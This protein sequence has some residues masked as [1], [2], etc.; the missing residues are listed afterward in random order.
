MKGISYTTAKKFC[1]FLGI[2]SKTLYSDLAKHKIEQ[3]NLIF[4]IYSKKNQPQLIGTLT[5]LD[6]ILGTKSRAALI[7]LKNNLQNNPKKGN[8]L[9]AL[10]VKSD[11]RDS[12]FHF[13]S[14]N[15]KHVPILTSLETW[16]KDNIK[17]LI[18]INSYR[19]RRFKY[20]YPTKGQRTRSNANTAYK[21]NRV[22]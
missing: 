3:L 2:S 4:N 7:P 15:F 19:G 10:R 11:I 16:T 9:G 8:P 5:D 21:L 13:C 12:Q 6:S 20:N 1:A 14:S 22:K 17:T 18:S